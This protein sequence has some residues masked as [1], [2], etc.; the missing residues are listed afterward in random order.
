MALYW[1]LGV[2]RW[3]W[4]TNSLGVQVWS[5]LFAMLFLVNII[6]VILFHPHVCYLFYPAQTKAGV[7]PWWEGMAGTGSAFFSLGFILCT[8]VWIVFS[9]LLWE[10]KP[11]DRYEKNGEGNFGK[12]FVVFVATLTLG[13]ILMYILLKVFNYVW[14]EAF[15]GGQYTDGPDWRCIHAGEIAGF[16]I[17][18]AFIWKNYFNNFPNLQSTGLRALI[19][20]VLVIVLGLLIYWFYFSPLATFFL[21]RVEG[22][23]Q[24]DDKPLVWTL[25]FLSVVLIQSEFFDG[26]P[27]KRK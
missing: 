23:A 3:P 6:Y 17:L 11:W 10:G 19:R 14:D 27:L 26:W 18:A 12:A 20:S 7:A 9:N 24:P 4:Q 15:M 5:K 2:G 22:F 25:M 8:L 21:A 16:F 13:V 1:E